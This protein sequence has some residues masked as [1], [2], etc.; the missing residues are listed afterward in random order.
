MAPEQTIVVQPVIGTHGKHWQIVNGL[1]GLLK[2][3]E[4][5]KR[6]AEAEARR[7]AKERSRG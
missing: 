5:T 1:G 7:L 6:K 4:G 2:Y 3:V